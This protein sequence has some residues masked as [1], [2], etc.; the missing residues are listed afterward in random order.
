MS[1]EE[2]EAIRQSKAKADIETIIRA[3]HRQNARIKNGNIRRARMAK[4]LAVGT[5]PTGPRA[6]WLRDTSRELNLTLQKC[7]E[8]FAKDNP[9][10]LI[11]IADM[12]DAIHTCFHQIKSYL[13]LGLKK[14]SGGDKDSVS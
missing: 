11:S 12:V 13:T 2:E 5:N 3:A 7:A 4:E 9:D 8:E 6:E 1:I 14:D 10:D